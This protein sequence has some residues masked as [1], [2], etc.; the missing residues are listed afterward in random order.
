MAGPSPQ[1]LAAIRQHVESEAARRGIT[2]EELGRRQ[3][4]QIEREAA[5]AGM[6]T[7]QYV[8]QMKARA[9]QA[10]QAQ[11]QQQQQPAG[12]AVPLNMSGPANPKAIAVA[13]FLRSQELK[14]RT[15]IF[16]G[17][18]RDMFKGE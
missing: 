1:Q 2:P 18:R 13:D 6:S 16:N 10:A 11:A 14:P 12:R 4:E 7:E 8:V 9:M 15:C 3:R 5:N 17:Q